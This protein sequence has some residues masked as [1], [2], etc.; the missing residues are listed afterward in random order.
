MSNNDSRLD[1]W[2]ER[3]LICPRDNSG[4]RQQG[5]QLVC[6]HGHRYPIADGIPI[7]LVGDVSQTVP[8][9][10]SRSLAMAHAR[11]SEASE[12]AAGEG[13]VDP[14]VQSA[15]VGTN[16]NLYGPLRGKLPRYPIPELCLPPARE[17]A[18]DLLDLGC[19]WG[20]WCIAAARQGYR[21]VGIDPG[22]ESILPARRIARQLGVDA[23]FLV[24]DARYIPFREGRFAVVHSY[25]VL[26]HFS[27]ADA[28]L[29]IAEAGRV[30]APGGIVM[31][32][33]AARFGLLSLFQQARRGF[34]D[35]RGFEV[36]YWKPSDIASAFNSLVGPTS[37]SVDGYLTLN[38]QAS[39]IDLLPLRYRPIVHLSGVL[40]ALSHRVPP[41][42][43]VADSIFATAVK[44]SAGARVGMHPYA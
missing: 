31:I 28:K 33:M 40:R 23:H 18:R 25:G 19:N 24:A 20:R 11:N 29:A 27:H 21:A 9:L 35:A 2:F 30:V 14:Y 10:T 44:N 17:D 15:I 39:D 36:R 8:E 37:L 12:N 42:L 22:L 5:D 16:G 3:E 34:R 38:P 1:P 13:A 7:M 6:T 4:L 41:M 43:R 26:Q 32:Q